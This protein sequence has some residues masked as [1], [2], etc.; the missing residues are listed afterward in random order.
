LAGVDRSATYNV[1]F[2]NDGESITATGQQLKE[3]GLTVHLKR[4]HSSELILYERTQ[5]QDER[6]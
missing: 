1:T 5:D 4:V 6:T 3:T 2:D